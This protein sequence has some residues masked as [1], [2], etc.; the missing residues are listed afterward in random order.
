MQNQSALLFLTLPH[1]ASN[2]MR[3]LSTF[4]KGRFSYEFHINS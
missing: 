3:V 2:I 1:F 4:V